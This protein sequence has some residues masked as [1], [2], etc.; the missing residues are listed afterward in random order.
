MTEQALM[1]MAPAQYS[2]PDKVAWMAAKIAPQEGAIVEADDFNV[3]HSFKG[4]WYIRE[5]ELPADFIF[6]GRKHLQGHIV[7]L[8]KGSSFLITPTETLRYCA[9]AMIHTKSGFY[10]VAH[11]ITP[12]LAQSWHLNPDGLRDI[13]ELESL[14]FEAP[15]ITLQRGAQLIQEALT[16]SEQ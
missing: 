11:T 9:P 13:D 3:R 1:N 15:L 5:F 10:T 7:K 2:W 16:W 12:I 6:I 14:Y 4:V 8:L